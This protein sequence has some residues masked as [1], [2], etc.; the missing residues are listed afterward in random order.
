MTDLLSSSAACTD[1]EEDRHLL[2]VHGY[3]GS[4][5]DF[6]PLIERLTPHRNIVRVDLPG[7][8]KSPRRD[9]Y[10]LAEL[11]VELGGFIDENFDRPI[12]VLGHSMGGRTVL[13][14]ITTRPERAS[15]L[16]LMD[17]WADHFDTGMGEVIEPIFQ[18]SDE[19]ILAAF[20][21]FA[22]E[23]EETQESVLTK[24]A[25]G[26]QW[27]TEHDDYNAANFD[28]KARVD[29]GRAIFTRGAPSML[30]AAAGIVV[31]TTI[32]VGELDLPFREPS[33]RMRET[34]PNARKVVIPGAYHSPQLSHSDQWCQA[35]INHLSEH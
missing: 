21:S 19:E 35:V 20:E 33:T 2:L 12:D 29:L 1:S 4:S 8:G 6:T 25:W 15:S 22:A 23:A 10:S 28:P 24:A 9:S 31:P 11:A 27:I 3:S 5:D 30:E 13:E 34:I 14:T 17:T 18:L 7:H 16:I 26:E 32:I